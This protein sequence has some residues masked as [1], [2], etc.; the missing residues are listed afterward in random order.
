MRLAG[1]DISVRSTAVAELRKTR[2]GSVTVRGLDRCPLPEGL[3]TTN[4]L[5]TD[6]PTVAE[7][8]RHCLQSAAP[9]P[10]EPEAVVFSMPEARVFTHLFSFP[11]DLDEGAVRAG[12]DVQFPEYFPFAL[13]EAA[14]DWKVVQQSDQTQMVLVAACER[15]FAEQYSDLGK[16]LGVV[17]AGIDIEPASTAR[18]VLPPVKGIEAYLLV[19]MGEHVTS[20]SLVGKAGLHST[21]VFQIG[22]NDVL[23]QIAKK[24]GLDQLSAQQVLRALDLTPAQKEGEGELFTLAEAQLRPVVEEVKQ[25]RHVFEASMRRPVSG[26]VLCGALSRAQGMTA[27]IQTVIDLPVT[28]ATLENRFRGLDKSAAGAEP[29]LLANVLGLTYGAGEK[30]ADRT[31]FNLLRHLH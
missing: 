4:N 7:K 25:A 5:I 14:Y 28:A 23:E 10:I 19:D 24:M 15:R 2:F 17:V 21:R 3:V 1:I 31:R 12:V 8:L 11:R 16:E 30:A 22:G 29:I 18:A 20:I 13:A 9:Q 6:V 27:F 26:V